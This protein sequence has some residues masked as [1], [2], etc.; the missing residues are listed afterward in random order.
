MYPS[1]V[2]K[3]NQIKYFLVEGRQLSY[4]LTYDYKLHGKMMG[5]TNN[6]AGH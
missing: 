1:S 3:K 6:R 2:L 5:A 4:I